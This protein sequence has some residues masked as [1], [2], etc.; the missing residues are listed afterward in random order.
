[1]TSK[2]EYVTSAGLLLLRVGIGCLMLVHGVVKIQAF[3][4]MSAAFPDPIGLGSK[5]RRILQ[6]N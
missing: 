5:L 1:M 3:S 2:Q 6:S 4:D